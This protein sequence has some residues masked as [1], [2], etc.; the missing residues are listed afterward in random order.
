MSMV[1][2]RLLALALTV[3]GCCMAVNAAERMKMSTPV[4]H[5]EASSVPVME[6]PLYDPEGADESYIMNVT[7][8]TYWGDEAVDGY[9]MT[10]RRSAD[11]KKI[12]F[13]DLTPG[14]NG[15]ANTEGYSWV[16]G[17]VEGNDI[18]IPAGQ[19]LYKTENQVLYFEVVSFDEYGSVSDFL[20]EIHFTIDGDIIS[21]TD[22][23]VRVGVYDNDTYN[24]GFF[25]FINQYNIQPIGDIF[26]FT[27][28]S[29]ATIEKWMMTSST[30]SRF[31][32]VAR[33]GND[34]YIAGFSSM[35]PDDYVMGTI[36]DGKLTFLSAY[37]LPSATLKYIRLI[38]AREGEPDEF[39]F[40][41]LE[42]IPTYEFDVNEAE[43]HFTLN[44]AGDYIV[45]ASYFNF[46]MLNGLSNVEVFRYAGDVPATPATPEI[47]NWSE[48]D[49]LVQFVIPS[50]DVDGNFINPDKLT[51]RIYLDGEL[52]KFTPEE[53][54]YLAEEM[55]DIPYAFTDN[56]DI[57]TN[58]S[59]KSIYLHAPAF[60]T[61]EVESTYTVDG[62]ARVSQRALYSG[63]ESVAANS[64]QIVS[65][66]YTDILGR[67]VA[68]PAPGSLLIKTSVHA[69]GTRT[70][71]KVIVR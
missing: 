57:Y 45:E 46:N 52:H 21:Q 43:D 41:Q 35:A 37:I 59:L 70:V 38:G 48:A 49:G 58:G 47:T 68:S 23:N 61:I 51:Y 60:T 22:N 20:D 29:D 27:P 50:T 1:K 11:G 40:P 9:K 53:Y 63:I 26:T 10:I 19:V 15:D 4:P 71:S 39:G 36:A 30:E 24:P 5:A 33:S 54:A 18:T 14:F 32:N 34:V 13:R 55:T 65:E 69:D 64:S 6:N 62:D 17:N 28:P 66:T 3:I 44:P 31:V 8:N 25:I 7:E 12:Y 56:Y 16:M 42:M 67:T 2:N